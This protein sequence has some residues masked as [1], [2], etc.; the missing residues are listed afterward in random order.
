MFAKT[1][2][3]RQAELVALFAR[4]PALE[5]ERGHSRASGGRTPYLVKISER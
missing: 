4:I 1:G 3:R 5:I 2:V